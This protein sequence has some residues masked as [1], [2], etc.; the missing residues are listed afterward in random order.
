MYLLDLQFEI[1]NLF[2]SRFKSLIDLKR[3]TRW[4]FDFLETNEEINLIFTP[5]KQLPES[6]DFFI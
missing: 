2:T 4:S 3:G 1:E 5:D 6:A